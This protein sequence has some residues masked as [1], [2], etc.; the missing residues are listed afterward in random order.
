MSYGF[1]VN[2]MRAERLTK[3]SVVRI[4]TTS[5]DPHLVKTP[6]SGLDGASVLRNELNSSA[7]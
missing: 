4:I 1:N 3:I 5:G 7:F 2:L 6:E